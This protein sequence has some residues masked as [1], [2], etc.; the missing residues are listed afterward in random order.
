MVGM[1]GKLYEKIEASALWSTSSGPH[2]N[3]LT[4]RTA[5]VTVTSW[6][7]QSP[8]YADQLLMGGGVTQQSPL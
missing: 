3:V 4:W 1:N 5:T 8:L 6:R 7:C 2:L